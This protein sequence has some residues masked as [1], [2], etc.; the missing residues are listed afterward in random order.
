MVFW[1]GMSDELRNQIVQLLE[2][3]EAHVVFEDAVKGLSF[4]LQG[5][6]PAGS[7]YSPWELLEHMRITQ[8]DILEYGRNPKHVSPEFPQGYWPPQAQ[9]PD[10]GAWRRSVETF[11]SDLKAFR[12]QVADESNDLLA[13]IPFAHNKTL[14]R[15]ALLAADHTSYHLGQLVLVRKLLGAWK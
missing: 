2:A 4:E 12:D 14:L 7:D 5:T 10:A 1:S 15:N 13:P 6:R 3:S 9:P 11:V 8:W